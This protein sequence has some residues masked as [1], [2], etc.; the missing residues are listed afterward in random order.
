MLVPKLF[1]NK[2]EQA[3]AFQNSSGTRRTKQRR[4]KTFWIKE[5]QT[6]VFL[7]FLEPMRIKEGRSNI[8]RRKEEHQKVFQSFLGTKRSKLIY[9]KT[10]QIKGKRTCSIV[11]KQ[12]KTREKTK[13][14]F[15][16]NEG[17]IEGI[18]SQKTRFWHCY[19]VQTKWHS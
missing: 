13:F 11:I 17:K 9:S 5:E 16:G 2:E 4:F 12:Q 3:E 7:N 18:R 19:T 10:L 14:R 1:R 6:K 8:F 15:F